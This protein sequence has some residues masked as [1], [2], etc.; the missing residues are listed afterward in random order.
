MELSTFLFT[1]KHA[2]IVH[3]PVIFIQVNCSAK[4]SNMLGV[5]YLT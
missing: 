4:F 5:H 1:C 2:V 3:E